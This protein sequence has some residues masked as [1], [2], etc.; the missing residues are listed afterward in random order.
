MR[1]P[2][3]PIH[4]FSLIISSSPCLFIF[5]DYRFIVSNF[6][7]ILLTNY[8]VFFAYITP[9]VESGYWPTR[10][11]IVPHLEGPKSYQRVFWM[12]MCILL[13]SIGANL[14]SKIKIYSLLKWKISYLLIKIR[15]ESRIISIN[16]FKI[17]FNDFFPCT[18]SFQF[19]F[20]S[21]WLFFWMVRLPR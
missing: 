11:P 3:N 9:A 8:R 2:Y 15:R 10:S 16:G 5:S 14:H 4:L 18:L 13:S 12:T 6:H 20:F 21:G 1:I 19:V 17:S 7:L